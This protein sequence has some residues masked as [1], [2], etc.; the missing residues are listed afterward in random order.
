[1][2]PHQSTPTHLVPVKLSDGTIIQMEVTQTGPTN[3]AGGSIF[4]IDGFKQRIKSLSQDLRDSLEQAKPTKV[5]IEFGLTLTTDNEDTLSAIFV[6]GSGEANLKVTLEW[7][8]KPAPTQSDP[9]K[10]GR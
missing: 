3:V 4:S 2:H 10:T 8:N 7:E 6:K 1:M 5:T 9:Q